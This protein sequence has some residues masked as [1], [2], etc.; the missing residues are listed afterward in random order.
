MAAWCQ[1]VATHLGVG[2]PIPD[3]LQGDLA[4]DMRIRTNWQAVNDLQNALRPNMIRNV[5]AQHRG[6]AGGGAGERIVGVFRVD[7]RPGGRAAHVCDIVRDVL[8]SAMLTASGMSARGVPEPAPAPPGG[9]V[10]RLVYFNRT[11]S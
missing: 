5:I 7:L 4:S 6:A 8:D 11:A 3:V 9:Y 2:W 1:D 10:K